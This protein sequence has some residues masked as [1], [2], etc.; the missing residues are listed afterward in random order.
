MTRQFFLTAAAIIVLICPAHALE[1][2]YSG[3]DMLA[4]CRVV[5][6]GSAPTSENAQLVG[7]CLGEIDAL[8][9][10]APGLQNDKLRSCVPDEVTIKQM[11]KA[12]VEFLDQNAERRSEPFE[13]LALEA[14]GHAWPCSDEGS[15]SGSE[16][17]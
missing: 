12:V 14:L 5:S 3:N 11:A 16:K 6:T 7:V 9:W 1:R 10:T 4:A 17:D 13:G 8:N 2:R 15:E